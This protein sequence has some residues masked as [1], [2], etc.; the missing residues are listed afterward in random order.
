[1]EKPHLS[2]GPWEGLPAKLRRM[3]A[4]SIRKG[5]A[6]DPDA[7]ATDAEFWKSAK[8]VMPTPKEI[9][10]M[11][12]DADLLRWFR[13]QRGYQ[14]R[15]NAIL[16]AYMQATWVA[17]RVSGPTFM[18]ELRRSSPPNPSRGAAAYDSP[19]VSPG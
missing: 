14:T 8:V 3:S 10:T 19:D 7:R 6:A 4:V 9:V 15:I 17:V 12:L 1:M 13:Q 11:R 18:S 5:I 16:R 2:E